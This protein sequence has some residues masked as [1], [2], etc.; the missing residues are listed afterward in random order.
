MQTQPQGE[1]T[2]PDEERLMAKTTLIKKYPN[3][4]L[5]D[6]Q[7]STYIT[8]SQLADLIREGTKV[9]VIDAKTGE[10]VTAFTLMQVVLEEARSKNALLPVSLL[11]LFIRYGENVLSEFFD[12]YLELTLKS[13]LTYKSTLDEQFGKWLMLN[14]D[15]ADMAQ[16]TLNEMTSLSS[17]WK[18]FNSKPEETEQ[19]PEEKA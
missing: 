14:R 6:T 16:E 7:L 8:L 3:R 2:T 10:D 15:L 12:K 11:H 17:F 1:P 19:D 9:T 4:R 18:V 5:Y 13:Y